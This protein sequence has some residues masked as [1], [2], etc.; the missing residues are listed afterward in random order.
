MASEDY[1]KAVGAPSRITLGGVD[2]QVAK[3]GPRIFGELQAFL[4]SFSPDPRLKAAE[5]LAALPNIANEVGLRIWDDFQREAEDWPPTLESAQGNLILCTTFEGA[6]Q[7]VWSLLRQHAAGMTWEKAGEIAE[8]VTHAEINELIALSMPE[9]DF[10]P[11]DP[12][13][14][15]EEDRGPVPS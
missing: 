11:K 4:K 9:R 5:I 8:R 3:Q 1:A 10:V 12:G 13:T 2:Y 6:R 15:T 7:V 14:P